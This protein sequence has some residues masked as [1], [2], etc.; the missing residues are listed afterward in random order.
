MRFI[1]IVPT[2]RMVEQADLCLIIVGLLAAQQTTM[3]RL[4]RSMMMITK[5]GSCVLQV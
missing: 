1:G 5:D 3:S 4:S 2:I